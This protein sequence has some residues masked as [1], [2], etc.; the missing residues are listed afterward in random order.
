M[1]TFVQIHY[2]QIFSPDFVIID[3]NFMP[4]VCGVIHC[5]LPQLNIRKL[6]TSYGY[7]LILV[8]YECTYLLIL[9]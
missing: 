1:H 5:M 6:L 9:L 3:S 2:Q 7:V 8:A 4:C